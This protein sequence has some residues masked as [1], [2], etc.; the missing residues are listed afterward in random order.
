[1]DKHRRH[2]RLRRLALSTCFSL[3]KQLALTWRTSQNKQPAKTQQVDSVQPVLPSVMPSF[4]RRQ[5]KQLI[6]SMPMK[7]NR[8]R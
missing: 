1:M 2:H 8:Q 6:G 5:E 7:F 3:R 4:S